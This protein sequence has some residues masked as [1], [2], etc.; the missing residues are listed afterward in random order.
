MNLPL[1]TCRYERQRV[2]STRWTTL[3]LLG[4]AD[5]PATPYSAPVARQWVR[6]L[7][8]G[9]VAEAA[10]DDVMLLL[11]EVVTNAVVHSDSSHSPSGSVTVCLAAGDGRLH[12]EV[13]DDG[14]AG[15]IPF[16]RASDPDSDGGRGLLLVDLIAT[17]WGAHHDQSSTVV[18]FHLPS[19]T[20]GQPF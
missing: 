17:D 15:S 9:K 11:S 10:L 3:R 5:F 2:A 14:S 1:V 7:L 19:G 13:I 6:H 16:V 20:S 8:A 4:H 18:W 12:I